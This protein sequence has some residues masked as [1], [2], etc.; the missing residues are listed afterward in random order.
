MLLDKIRINIVKCVEYFEHVLK[1]LAAEQYTPYLYNYSRTP[2]T[3]PLISISSQ[4]SGQLLRQPVTQYDNLDLS[5]LDR[6]NLDFQTSTLK[7]RLY[8]ILD[9]I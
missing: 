4:N 9:S 5:N 2:I 6:S 3:G 7:L 8:C 1:L